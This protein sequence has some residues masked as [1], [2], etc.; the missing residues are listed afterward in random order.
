MFLRRCLYPRLAGA[1][2]SPSAAQSLAQI[3]LQCIMPHHTGT[4]CRATISSISGESR[5]A[6]V[7]HPWFIFDIARSR[8]WYKVFFSS[9]LECAMVSM[10]ESGIALHPTGQK[11]RSNV[12]PSFAFSSSAG[13]QFPEK[14]LG[15]NLIRKSQ[16][17]CF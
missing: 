13:P 16:C 4:T 3:D 7:G 6:C 17:D 5:R 8:T 1:T 12:P 10:N 14:P 9:I 11:G 15:I 2:G